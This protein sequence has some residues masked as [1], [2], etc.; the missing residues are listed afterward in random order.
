MSVDS[1]QLWTDCVKWLI[2]CQILDPNHRVTYKQ[3]EIVDFAQVLRDGVLLCQL[4]HRLCKTSIDIRDVSLRP[5]LSQ[6][7]FSF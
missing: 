4:A 1:S 3:A 5:Q 7:T 6:V 2:R